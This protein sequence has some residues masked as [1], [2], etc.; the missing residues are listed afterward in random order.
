MKNEINLEEIL[1][2]HIREFLKDSFDESIIDE[3]V[4]LWMCMMEEKSIVLKAM[5]EACKQTLEL[6]SKNAIIKSYCKC[7]LKGSR[8]KELIDGE[9]FD[10]DNTTQKYSIDKKSILNTINQIK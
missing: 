2:A 7:N 9:T 8:Y 5:K 3:K 10:F 1:T 6:A 4:P